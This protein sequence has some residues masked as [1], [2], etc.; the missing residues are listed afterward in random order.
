VPGEGAAEV[1]DVREAVVLLSVGHSCAFGCGQPVKFFSA[2]GH[3]VPSGQH[4]F[5]AQDTLPV[6]GHST[7]P[8]AAQFAAGESTCAALGMSSIGI[9]VRG[10]P[11]GMG[12]GQ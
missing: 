6:P 4:E 9:A 8:P 11:K 2:D 5:P 10:L 7:V 3:V 12:S 1:R